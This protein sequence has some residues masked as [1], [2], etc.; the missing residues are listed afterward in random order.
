M[1]KWCPGW[2]GPCNLSLSIRNIFPESLGYKKFSCV[3]SGYGCS[4][5]FPTYVN[6][7]WISRIHGEQQQLQQDKNSKFKS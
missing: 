4:S 7:L 2:W 3:V 5:R 1:V 6:T